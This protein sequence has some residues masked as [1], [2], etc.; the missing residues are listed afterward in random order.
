M[1][2]KET[3][4]RCIDCEKSLIVCGTKSCAKVEISIAKK[5][6]KPSIRLPLVPQQSHSQEEHAIA[7]C[8]RSNHKI[9]LI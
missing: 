8:I 5:I 4:I 9:E 7:Q 2:A 3:N 1:R 6:N